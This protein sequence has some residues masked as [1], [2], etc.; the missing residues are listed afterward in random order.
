MSAVAALV[1]AAIP[2]LTAI[3]LLGVARVRLA[4]NERRL[5]DVEARVASSWLADRLALLGR[6][7][8]KTLLDGSR[9]ALDARIGAFQSDGKPVGKNDLEQLDAELISRVLAGGI[10]E[11]EIGGQRC[12]VAAAPLPPPLS[13]ISVVV[14]V[15]GGSAPGSQ[16][17]PLLRLGLLGLLL[18]V[19]AAL[20]GR[21]FGVELG[22]SIT[23]LGRWLSGCARRADRSPR[24]PPGPASD[25]DTERLARAAA[26][27]DERTLE[28]LSGIGRQRAEAE[29]RD[30]RRSDLFSAVAVD[31][32]CP[33]DAVIE[34]TRA[35]L[36]GE[37]GEL[38]ESQRDDIAIVNQASARLKGM[39]G[40][41]ADFSE[42]V[43]GRMELDGEPVEIAAVARE[44]V[45]TARGQVGKKRLELRVEIGAG[46]EA[47]PAVPG[48]RDRLWQVLTNL[49][50][51]AIKFTEQGGV[52]VGV[53]RDE[54]GGARVDVEDTGV[55]ISRSDLSSVF[56]TFRQLGAVS[57]RKRGTG[58]G[59]PICKRL[60][61]LHGGTIDVSSSPG[62]GTR[63]TVRLPEAR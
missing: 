45:E 38:Q 4:E 19:A 5:E 29:L 58:L 7:S 49:V 53:R 61:Q 20:L 41:I 47:P 6:G 8:W 50:G 11:L 59:L 56:D 31:L 26:R 40:E 12:R 57:R 27:L 16:S 2:L 36:D 25:R 44:V 37:H 60:V 62:R 33:I 42:L 13:S 63:V 14:A 15:R 22:S 55:G 10:D 43:D 52:T 39:L 23:A 48:N 1:T 34:T 18:V 17:P 35:L 54:G 21:S 3:A 28:E 30:E 32:H 9:E 51:N 24:P 46:D